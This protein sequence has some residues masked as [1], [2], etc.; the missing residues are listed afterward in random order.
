MCGLAGYGRLGRGNAGVADD[1]LA[2]M[3]STLR[4][5][6][7]DGTDY[8]TDEEV[9]LAFNRLSIVDPETGGQPIISQDGSVVL[10]ANGEVY[11]HRE[12]AAKLPAGTRFRGGS[13]CEVLVHLYQRDGLRFLDEVRGIFAVIIW[14]RRRHRLIFARDRFG[15][16]P[17]YFHVA[18]DHIVFA[19]EI[20]ALFADPRCP[21]RLD[22]AACLASQSITSQPVFETGAPIT[23]F[24]GVQSVPA[25][26]V[27]EI[28]VPSG[29]THNHQYWRLPD[30]AGDP[31]ATRSELVAAYRDALIKS[32]AESCMSDAEIGVMLSGGIDSAAV[33]ALANRSRP[34]PAFTSLNG[35]TL[36]NG[37]GEN[38]HLVAQALGLTH[39]QVALP[40]DRVPGPDQW[41]AL[42]WQLET[43]LCG[44]EQFCKFEI[45]RYA[46]SVRPDLKVMLLGQA[47]D[48]F[49][50]GY[51]TVFAEDGWDDFIA[52]LAYMRRGTK[53]QQ[54]PAMM[55]WWSGPSPL[56]R[57]ESIDL[58]AGSDQD[59]LYRE[60]V[61]WKY[62]DI[63]QFNCWHEDRTAAGNAIEARVPFLDHRVVEAAAAVPARLRPDLLWDKTILR[64]ALDGIVPAEVL[65]RPKAGFHYGPGEWRVN[66]A[67]AQMLLADG[68]A[69]L[70]EALSGEQAR[71]FLDGAAIA[72][73]VAALRAAPAN[74]QLPPV[75]RLVNLGLL[76]QMLAAPPAAGAWPGPE[77]AELVIRDWEQERDAITAVI[78]GSAGRPAPGA[79]LAWSDDAM[80]V[81]P[82]PADGSWLIAMDG[83][84][85]YVVDEE[86][87]PRWAKLL[88]HVDGERSFAELA[89][90]AGGSGE[91]LA[92]R[93]A[94][95]I[96]AGVLVA[97]E[98][99]EAGGANG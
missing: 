13:D 36:G 88:A 56:L 8:Y 69:L 94:E 48:E 66:R 31:A 30:L 97:H 70:E 46:R 43:P 7:P 99:A 37:D 5:R 1:L 86:A 9:G 28:E 29:R 17:L 91:E 44:P 57:D 24:E 82:V 42:L 73:A 96:A 12:L 49:N 47:S 27:V 41:R 68:G 33:A 98:P 76:E 89:A 40:G 72:G 21:R 39:Y 2:A 54:A 58:I 25:A 75:L 26:T 51:S 65:K 3:A 50:G 4:H 63:Q 34:T 78:H 95:A 22:W 74:G 61:T 23:F 45:H 15:I 77:P 79:V 67:F 87:D 80:L 32:V 11:N 90:L 55:S 59:D 62:R 84:F 6:G 35:G 20:K 18:S 64:E 93:L 92:G 10:I 85:E 19:S 16:K 14:D 81:A 60:F 71:R 83:A 53:L 52:R 38:A